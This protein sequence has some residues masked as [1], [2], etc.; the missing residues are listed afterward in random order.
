MKIGESN[1]SLQIYTQYPRNE[2]VNQA[3][4]KQAEGAAAQEEKVNLS[5]KSQNFQQ[6][7]NALANLPDSRDEKI[8]ALKTQI[9][10]GTYQVNGEAVAKNM[11]KESAMDLGRI[12]DTL[13]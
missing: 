11:V 3:V 6:I 9:E 8:Q 4:G 10:K 12:V 5:T 7:K 1:D 13:A 2:N